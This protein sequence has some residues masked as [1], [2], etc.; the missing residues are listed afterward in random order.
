[1]AGKI[2]KNSMNPLDGVSPPDHSYG[3]AHGLHWITAALFIVADMAGGGVVTLPIAM[4]AAGETAGTIGIIIIAISF[5]YT[6][7]LLGEN[8]NTMCRKWPVYRDHCRKP[9]P[10]MAYRSMGKGARYFTSLVLNLMLYGVAMVYLSLSAKIMNDIVTGVFNV[11]IGTCLMIPILALLLF[12]VT[13]LKSPAD[14]QFAV[15]TAMVTTTLSVILIFYGTATDKESCEREVS[16]PPFSSTS[17]LL[18]LGTFMFGFGGHGVFPTIQHDM[19]E[20]RHFTRSSVLA[21]SIVLALYLPITYLGYYTY[22]D[23]LKHSIINSIQSSSVQQAANFFIAIHCI[24]TL[25][26]VIN[27][28][29]QEVEHKFKLPHAFGPTRIATRFGMMFVIVL[30]CLLIPDFDPILN[31]IGGTSV[32]LTSAIMPCLFNLY[33]HANNDYEAAKR[34]DNNGDE[35][36]GLLELTKR[37]SRVVTKTS[38]MK[39]VINVLVIVL[40]IICGGITTYSAIQ[41]LMSDGTGFIAPCFSRGS[42]T[43]T[44]AEQSWHC[45]GHYLNISSI[46]D[47]TCPAVI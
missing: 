37:R 15:V 27:P 10:E 46:P 21:F 36:V 28:L 33:L 20:P 44:S 14:F 35:S 47:A 7:H 22:G 45:C 2:A 11:H 39:L 8:W 25:T 1:M 4:L 38:S 18:S 32:A 26:I 3:K 23:S 13:L 6:A 43:P 16:Y 24:L 40:A 12:P 19:K 41:K 30:S 29:N 17:F 34:D 42:I 31:F 9:Y 5:C